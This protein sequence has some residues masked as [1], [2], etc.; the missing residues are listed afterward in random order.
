[1]IN[2]NL[3]VRTDFERPSPTLV[4]AFKEIPV[5]NIAD[6]M[7]RMSCL[8]SRLYPLNHAPLLGVALTVKTTGGD[9]LL[10]HKA[11]D[12]AK[13]GDVIVV[14]GGGTAHR[15]YAGEIMV[16]YAVSR[17]IAG[18]VVDGCMRDRD[19]IRSLDFPVYCVGITPNGPYKNGPGEI[20]YPV[21]CGGQV[22][23]PGDILVGDGDGVVVIKPYEAVELAEKARAVCKSEE[24]QL[25]SIADGKGLDRGW[26][27][28]KLSAGGYRID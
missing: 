15:S 18:F 1:M 11:L 4:N 20:N 5:A 10:L 12:L 6:C 23:C 7:N 19:E 26:I 27:D 14:A 13:P 8:D 24:S 21:S 28:V 3:R 25:N 2:S 16:R 9:N 22:I 17:G